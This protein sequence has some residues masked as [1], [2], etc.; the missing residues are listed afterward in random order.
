LKL[1]GQKFAD[2]FYNDIV[3]DKLDGFNCLI[4]ADLIPHLKPLHATDVRHGTAH[5]VQD[6]LILFGDIRSYLKDND[7]LIYKSPVTRVSSLSQT[8]PSNPSNITES[9]HTS[10]N[11][12]VNLAINPKNTYFNPIAFAK[13]DSDID[14]N[15]ENLFKIESL[16]I[17]EDNI[18]K[19]SEEIVSQFDNSIELKDGHYH[20]ELPFCEEVAN[21]PSNWKISLAAANRVQ[22]S[23]KAKGLFEEYD[24]IFAKQ[25]EAGTIEE[26]DVP[27]SELDGHIF[28][29]HHPVVKQDS[30]VTTKVRAVFNCSFKPNTSLPSLNQ[31]CF[32][33]IDLLADLVQ[34]LMKFRQNRYVIISDIEKAFL[35]IFLK[36]EQDKD[37]FCFFWRVNGEMKVFRYKTIIFGLNVSP[38][39]LNRVIQYH[40]NKFPDSPSI[41]ALKNSF[42]VDNFV[43]STSDINEL[44]EIYN[45]SRRIMSDGGFTLRSWMTNHSVLRQQMSDDMTIVQHS[46]VVEKLLGYMYNPNTDMISI[47]PY[48]EVKHVKLTKRHVLSQISKVFD[49]LSLVLPVTIRGRLLMKKIWSDDTKWDEEVSD[50]LSQ[51]WVKLQEDLSS[52]STISFPRMTTET[53]KPKI[54]HVFCDGSKSCY[55]FNCYA[56]NNDSSQLIFA[57][58]KVTPKAKSI[59]QIELLSVYLSFKCMPLILKSHSIQKDSEIH[60]WVDAQI[61]LEWILTG[62]KTKNKFTKNRILDILNARKEIEA[63]FGVKV[64]FHYIESK[65]NPSDMITRGLSFKDFIKHKELWLHGPSWMKTKSE[66]PVHELKCLSEQS[67]N[68]MNVQVN[69]LINQTPDI[70]PFLD[71]NKFSDVNKLHRITSYVLKFVNKHIRK[72]QRDNVHEAKMYWLK[73]MQQQSFNKELSYLDAIQNKVSVEQP[74]P[75]YVN[76]LNLF[77]NKAGIMCCRGRISN[78]SHFN[79]NVLLPV[80]LS[81]QH[82][83]TK[84]IVNNHHFKCKH[85]GVG[86]TLMQLREDGYWL[87]GGRQVVKEIISK[88]ITCKKLNTQAFAYPRLTNLPKERINLIKPFLHTGIDYTGHLYI[89]NSEGEPTKMYIIS[90]TC[91]AIRSVHLDLVPDITL[92]SFIQSFKRFCNVYCVPQSIYIHRQCKTIPR[93]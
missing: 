64:N 61:V 38:F 53:N 75:S 9:C 76:D 2:S 77:V 80:L 6:G 89:N 59:P 25:L 35:Q 49:P 8:N 14:L 57:K 45:E 18:S 16:G 26:I 47:S 32:E 84:L 40:L 11:I 83:L 36:H 62:C 56:T 5:V 65:E 1:H 46:E 42:Y 44:H 86:T 60:V 92:Q 21:V 88:C 66:W 10:E 19:S 63:Q 23:V 82:H 37:K 31:T 51:P 71:I 50:A 22:D 74:I 34:L 12:L 33:G 41:T 52:L 58:G 73:I 72:I 3:T 29:P 69:S 93:Q 48:E 55:G 43:Y 91:L 87:P 39:V 79:N 90:Y 81:K 4:G 13:N 17:K 78:S 68:V 24:G 27:D 30:Q 54:V 20:V 7:S 28:I 85:L 70:A 67:K 15:V